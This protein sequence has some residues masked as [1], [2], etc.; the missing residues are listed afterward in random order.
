MA[1]PPMQSAPSQ[2]PVIGTIELGAQSPAPDPTAFFVLLARLA[3]ELA[4][5]GGGATEPSAI[6]M[7]RQR[8]VEWIE[9]VRS[10][11]AFEP[12][13]A[14]VEALVARLSSALAAMPAAGGRS[15]LAGEAIAIAAEL[16]RVTQRGAPPPSPHVPP[17]P[18]FWK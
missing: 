5:Q 3:G 7:I 12:F 4:K 18:A 8:L 2:M 17:R 9:D 14:A 10:V 11:G 1:P 6:R 15:G 16:V 13:A